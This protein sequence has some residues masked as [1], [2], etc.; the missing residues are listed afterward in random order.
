MIF[1]PG[2][3][4]TGFLSQLSCPCCTPNVSLTCP[5]CPPVQADQ[6]NLIRRPVL[7]YCP[8]C[9]ISAVLSWLSC[10][11]CPDPVV[12]SQLSCPLSFWAPACLSHPN[13]TLSFPAVLSQCTVLN[14]LS[15]FPVQAILSPLSFHV[16][17]PSFSGVLSM[18]L[19]SGY[20]TLSCP[21]CPVP[22]VLSRPSTFVANSP[23]PAP[24]P[25]LAAAY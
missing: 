15:H 24:C 18:R 13:C 23:A 10:N 16:V 12:L 17:L 21:S 14:V 11:G 2:C 5:L 25:D 3:P 9:L 4:V 1:C 19:C 22:A 7:V 20:P 8:G 6:T